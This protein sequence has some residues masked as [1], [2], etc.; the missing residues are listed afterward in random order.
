MEDELIDARILR[1]DYVVI[2]AKRR[3]D[4]DLLSHSNKD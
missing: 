1:S 4:D 2:V 3:A